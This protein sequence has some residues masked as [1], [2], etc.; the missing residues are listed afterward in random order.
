MSKTRKKTRSVAPQ[1]SSKEETK[2]LKK[3]T[4]KPIVEPPKLVGRT[5]TCHKCGRVILQASGV[6]DG[7]GEYLCKKCYSG[8]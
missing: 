2:L 7:G 5:V 4:P 6:Y 3:V 1:S 8:R